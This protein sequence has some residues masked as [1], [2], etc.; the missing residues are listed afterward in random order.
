MSGLKQSQLN[1][2]NKGIILSTPKQ[3]LQQCSHMS[4]FITDRNSTFV[5]CFI[6]CTDAK[7]L[8]VYRLMFQE[9]S[10]FR[11]CNHKMQAWRLSAEEEGFN[12][13]GED[14]S[15]TNLLKVLRE[16]HVYG[17]VV[18]IRWFGGQL[19]GPVRFQHIRNTARNAITK[20]RKD[21]QAKRMAAM[22]KDVKPLGSENGLPQQTRQV[23]TQKQR[24]L[25]TKDKT[26]NL[27]RKMLGKDPIVSADYSKKT[28]EILNML[29]HSRNSMILALREELKQQREGKTSIEAEEK[30]TKA[31]EETANAKA[32]PAAI[33]Q[34]TK[35]QDQAPS[36]FTKPETVSSAS[37][38][39]SSTVP[40][41]PPEQHLEKEHEVQREKQVEQ[42]EEISDN[43]S[44]LKSKTT[45]LDET[46]EN[47]DAANSSVPIAKMETQSNCESS[48]SPEN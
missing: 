43:E 9:S 33:T 26:V 29:I 4:N 37:D 2:T 19:L 21:L 45:P 10:D 22:M 11:H 5:S 38:S 16:E 44:T 15:G 36:D 3:S 35:I 13:D 42:H 18:C 27:L 28:L 32:E 6:P 40:L 46:I 17:L 24:Q 8:P 20:Y 25:L 14:W 1:F 7:M 12:D 39:T 31:N 30:P 47:A 41:I 23:L 48:A 34:A